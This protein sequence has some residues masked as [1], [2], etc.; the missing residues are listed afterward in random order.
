MDWRPDA[1][2]PKNGKTF[3]RKKRNPVLGTVAQMTPAERFCSTP[4]KWQNIFLENTFP[5]FGHCRMQISWILA[6]I[7]LL[8]PRKMAKHFP[9]KQETSILALSH[10]YFRL[11]GAKLCIFL[12]GDFG[13]FIFMIFTWAYMVLC[14]VVQKSSANYLATRVFAQK[15]FAMFIFGHTFLSIFWNFFDFCAK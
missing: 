12:L 15:G 7:I 4:Q 8:Y 9:G 2:T 14:I 5:H 6:E 3:F 1:C 10:K 13:T 11:F